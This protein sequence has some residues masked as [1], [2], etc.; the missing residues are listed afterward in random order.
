MANLAAFLSAQDGSN[1]QQEIF[2]EPSGS[3]VWVTQL[4]M[5][6]G[7]FNKMEVAHLAVLTRSKLVSECP[8]H[9]AH[10]HGKHSKDLNWA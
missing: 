1:K 5:I 6:L 7:P 4:Q 9:K 8:E 3:E 10:K 2:L